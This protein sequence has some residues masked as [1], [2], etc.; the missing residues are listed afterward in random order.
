MIGGGVTPEGTTPSASCRTIDE[1]SV[2]RT[3]D[4]CV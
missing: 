4:V 3:A 1:T 2:V